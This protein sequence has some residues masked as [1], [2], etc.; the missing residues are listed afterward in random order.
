MQ[1]L[2]KKLLKV[3]ISAVQCFVRYSV[4]FK[5]SGLECWDA[6]RCMQTMVT[7]Y[8]CKHFDS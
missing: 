6:T 3:A 5:V 4:Y 8:Y 2:W 1:R 7:D